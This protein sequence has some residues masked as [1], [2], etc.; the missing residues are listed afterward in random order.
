[1]A[2][3]GY[4]TRNN[5]DV[6]RCGEQVSLTAMTVGPKYIPAAEVSLLLI[7]TIIGP[8]WVWLAVDEAPS[9]HTVFA[10]LVLVAALAV[11]S[12]LAYRDEMATEAAE[13]PIAKKEVA[14]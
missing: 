11:H 5:C 12:V 10:G 9:V 4:S 2:W 1:M 6:S 14:P 7:E 3:K 13:P 8:F